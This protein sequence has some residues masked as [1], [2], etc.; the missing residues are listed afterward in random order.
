VV[1]DDHGTDGDG[2]DVEEMVGDGVSS[3]E[4]RVKR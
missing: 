2:M 3:D 1:H 4:N